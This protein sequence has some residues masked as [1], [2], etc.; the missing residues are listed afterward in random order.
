HNEDVL[1]REQI[2]CGESIG[3]FNRHMV[4]FFRFV[5]LWFCGAFRLFFAKIGNKKHRSA[6]LPRTLGAVWS[7]AS[8]A[9]Y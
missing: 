2:D 4:T 6:L 8:G 7:F 3:N 1:L 9:R 5:K